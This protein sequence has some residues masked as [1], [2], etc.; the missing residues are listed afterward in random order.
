MKTDEFRLT[1]H[2]PSASGNQY[3]MERRIDTWF[4]FSYW[5]PVSSIS[6]ELEDAKRCIEEIRESEKIK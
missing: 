2:Y 4:G 3:F 6:L 5:W 1:L